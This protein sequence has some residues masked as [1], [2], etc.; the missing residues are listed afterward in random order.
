MRYGGRVVR[1]VCRLSL[2]AA[3]CV[4]KTEG[5]FGKHGA[6]TLLFAKFVPGLSAVAP[7]IAGQTG[8]S[9]VRFLTY[10][11]AGSLIWS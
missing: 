1:L 3:T 10:E 6:T 5:Y 2:E 11:L 7:P 8:M 9:Y 4:R